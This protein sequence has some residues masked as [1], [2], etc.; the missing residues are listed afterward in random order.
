M[1]IKNLFKWFS[2]AKQ[3]IDEADGRSVI[4]VGVFAEAET[5]EEKLGRERNASKKKDAATY[6][7]QRGRLALTCPNFKYVPAVSTDVRITMRAYIDETMPE[8]K[9]AY[10]FLYNV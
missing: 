4:K 2:T 1:Q 5:E 6:L 7:T 10:K 9:D 3:A 8:V